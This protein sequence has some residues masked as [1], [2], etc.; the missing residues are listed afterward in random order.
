MFVSCIVNS[1]GL[2]VVFELSN[3]LIG[4]KDLIL[5]IVCLSVWRKTSRDT[6]VLPYM[7]EDTSSL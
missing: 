4:I 5:Q 1:L 7:V 6:L 2:A 3:F